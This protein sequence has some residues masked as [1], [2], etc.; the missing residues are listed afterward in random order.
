M[1]L[2]NVLDTQAVDFVII[3]QRCKEE[4]CTGSPA[5]GPDP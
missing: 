3:L 1:L 2:D 4:F 5:K